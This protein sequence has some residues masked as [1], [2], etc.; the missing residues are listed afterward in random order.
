MKSSYT[1]MLAGIILVAAY[2]C[3]AVQP[4]VEELLFGCQVAFIA[5]E[6]RRSCTSRCANCL[7]KR[8][9]SRRKGKPD[10]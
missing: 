10:S 9:G 4:F 8:H 7:S 5:A 6:L 2:T 1:S 3:G